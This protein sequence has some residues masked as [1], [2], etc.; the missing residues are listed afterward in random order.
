MDVQNIN[1]L[2]T[3]VDA[4]EASIKLAV[5]H[6]EFISDQLVTALMA[7][8]VGKTTKEFL[9]FAEKPASFMTPAG[10][11][12][13]APKQIKDILEGNPVQ[14]ESNAGYSDALL[15]VDVSEF[16]NF[17]ISKISYNA[18]R[19]TFYLIVGN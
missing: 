12:D 9:M 6:Q 17:K 7:E 10:F 16:L 18:E 11:V 15:S 3:M 13:I 2:I 14:I 5:C 8:F 4:G 19:G 1:N